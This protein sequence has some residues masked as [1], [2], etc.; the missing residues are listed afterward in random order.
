MIEHPERVDQFRQD[1]A[2]MQVRDPAAGRDRLFARGGLTL[3]IIGV[4]VAI[5]GYVQSH[6]TTNPLG[7][8]DAII[9]GLIG[10]AVSVV[11]SALFLRGSI[12]GFLRFWL[13]RLIYEQKAQ[14]DRIVDR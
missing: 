4:I 11:G 5:A 6:G 12:A 14:T 1:I 13:A 3:M 10:V 8:R 9:I 7:Q 2:A